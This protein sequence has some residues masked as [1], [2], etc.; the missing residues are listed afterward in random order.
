MIK[1]YLCQLKI[2]IYIFILG[3]ESASNN[4]IYTTSSP[5]KVTDEEKNVPQS[6]SQPLQPFQMESTSVNKKVTNNS[7]DLSTPSQPA[8]KD[9]VLG[10]HVI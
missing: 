6:Y 1:Y 8:E 7:F 9:K 2:I 10:I 3:P 5:F 4:V